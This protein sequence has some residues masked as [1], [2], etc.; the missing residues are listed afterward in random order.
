MK[1]L[2]QFIT[3]MVIF[4]TIGLIIKQIHINSVEIAMLSSSIG[5]IFL[6]LIYIIRNK[7]LDFSF[8]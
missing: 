8:F 4:G 3:S 5:C 7:T 1:A 6:I 2:I